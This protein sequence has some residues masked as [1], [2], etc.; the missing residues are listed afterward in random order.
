MAVLLRP[1]LP[2]AD[3]AGAAAT[4]AA[5]LVEGACLACEGHTKAV[6]APAASFATALALN[7]PVLTL[8]DSTPVPLDDPTAEDSARRAAAAA[9]ASSTAAAMP[10]YLASASSTAAGT[11]PEV[12]AGFNAMD[13]YKQGQK[14]LGGRQPRMAR[15]VTRLA[16]CGKRRYLSL[17]CRSASSLCCRRSR[18]L[19][20]SARLLAVLAPLP[21]SL[22]A[23]LLCPMLPLL[24]LLL[25]LLMRLVSLLLPPL[26]FLLGSSAVTGRRPMSR[27][28]SASTTAT[29]SFAASLCRSG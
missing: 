11:R 9:S 1:S 27:P 16:I 25:V 29:R 13:A 28:A 10:P 8:D 4:V 24:V 5:P 2:V 19:L 12:G 17:G 20:V 22:L 23:V 7:D 18:G 14:L 26:T 6:A 3:G 21:P 15:A